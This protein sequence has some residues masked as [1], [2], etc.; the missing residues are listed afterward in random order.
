MKIETNT[1][2]FSARSSDQR[3]V[4]VENPY[5]GRDVIIANTN[6]LYTE[7][8][9]GHAR[10][11]E[12]QHYKDL[13]KKDQDS[14][15]DTAAD[16][17]ALNPVYDSDLVIANTNGSCFSQDD[18]YTEPV[19]DDQKRNLRAHYMGLVKGNQDSLHQ[20]AAARSSINP[21]YESSDYRNAEAEPPLYMELE[22]ETPLG[23]D[24]AADAVLNP[25]YNSST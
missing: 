9:I 20:S 3:P 12:A 21:V 19:T 5:Y 17:V 18:L 13:V 14:L 10:K 2:L 8:V 1:V 23:E 11:N 6:E 7:P 22:K 16:G 24:A 15:Y 4:S 25:I